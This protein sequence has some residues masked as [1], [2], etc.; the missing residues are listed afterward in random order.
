M[1]AKTLLCSSLILGGATFTFTPWTYAAEFGD[2]TP[3]YED[4]AWYDISEWFDGN[5]YNPTDETVGKWDDERYNRTA[6]GNTDGDN[7]GSYG[8]SG[9]NTSDWFYDYYDGDA[10]SYYSGTDGYYSYGSRYYDYD[11]DGIYDGFTSYTDWDNDGLYD[12]ISYYSFSDV[13]E[14]KAKQQQQAK[15]DSTGGSKA[16]SVTGS[17]EK[18]KQ[19]DVRGHKHTL[20]AVQQDGKAMNIDLGHAQGVEYLNLKAGTK[21]TATGPMTKV[22]DKTLVLAKKL[23]VDGKQQQIHRERPEMTGKV[24]DT[25]KTKVRGTEHLLAIVDG[26]SN[27]AGKMAVDLGPADRLS[28][29]VQKGSQLTFTGVPIKVKDKR[30]VI[31]QSVKQPNGETTQIQRQSKNKSAKSGGDNNPSQ[32]GDKTSKDEKK[33]QGQ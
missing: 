20:V 17:I 30:L 24:T 4:D 31:A 26:S 27:N 22:G 10:Y 12:V 11:N 7:D 5:D 21:I 14:D 32:G 28:M 13:N 33:G 3:Y 1:K 19:V 9:G 25:R 2:N 18:V 29:K 16:Q 15:S 6:G 23:E 8:Y